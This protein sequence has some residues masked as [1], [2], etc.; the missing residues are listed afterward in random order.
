MNNM[1]KILISNEL[2][3]VLLQIEQ[4]SLVARLLL[5]GEF[6]EDEL[7]KDYV[8]YISISTN[9]KT[10]ISYLTDE[11][12]QALSEDSYWT[13]SRRFQ[14]KPGG[15]ISKLFKN[16]SGI[17]VEKFSTLFRNISNK[18]ECDFKIVQGN[19]IAK[20]YHYSTYRSTENGSLGASCMKHDSCQKYMD[21]Y[22]ENS[23]NIKLLVLLD[24]EGELIGR[25]LL[26][27]F[28]SY[29]IMD[30]IYTINDEQ[31]QFYFKQWASNNGYMFKANQN[32]YDCMTFEDNKGNKKQLK[33]KIDLKNKSFDYYPYLDTFKFR[34]SKGFI[35]NYIPDDIDLDDMKTLISTDG[36]KLSGNHLVLLD[37]GHYKQRNESYFLKYLNIWT[38]SNSVNWSDVNDCYIKCQDSIYDNEI[39]D[40]IYNSEYDS[41][42]DLERINEKKERIK[43][44][45]DS[46]I[47]ELYGKIKEIALDHNFYN[48]SFFDE[49]L[50]GIEND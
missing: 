30:R 17:E 26:W 37:S 22:N 39:N 42:N 41:F 5:N 47:S 14:I 25:A 8:N 18:I 45:N 48:S 31:Y 35:Y 12:K 32:W 3:E 13:S 50:R 16:I 15:F 43:K 11:R 38:Q 28:D 33:L 24:D 44:R 4:Q 27:Y 9:D 7:V 36:S 49:I 29:K 20:Y 19:S 46:N 6:N 34:D 40:Y 2:K 21:F 10:K 23:D 1:V